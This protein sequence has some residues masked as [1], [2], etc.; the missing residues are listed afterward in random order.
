[1]SV[2]RNRPG[3][4][5]ATSRA[6][7]RAAPRPLKASPPPGDD[8]EGPFLMPPPDSDSDDWQ[9]I[10]PRKPRKTKQPSAPAESAAGPDQTAAMP[11]PLSVTPAATTARRR[12]LG[13][14]LSASGIRLRVF[15]ARP[16]ASGS[17]GKKVPETPTSAPTMP[18]GP[19]PTPSAPSVTPVTKRGRGRPRKTP[20]P[21]APAA[22]VSS[23]P[24]GVGGGSEGPPVSAQG[25]PGVLGGISE[26]LV[27]GPSAYTPRLLPTGMGYDPNQ[28]MPQEPF[29]QWAG[30]YG[31]PPAPSAAASSLVQNIVDQ[32]QAIDASFRQPA[33]PRYTQASFAPLGGWPGPHQVPQQYGPSP[34]QYSPGPPPPAPGP[35]AWGGGERGFASVPTPQAGE[36]DV[37]L[38]SMQQSWTQAPIG[39]PWPAQPLARMGPAGQLPPVR[40]PYGI[41]SAPGEFSSAFGLQSNLLAEQQQR[42]EPIPPASFS[43]MSLELPGG[44]A[45][46]G[47]VETLRVDGEEVVTPR[48]RPWKAKDPAQFS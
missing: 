38:P 2:A 7:P 11:P 8:D 35:W 6:T 23:S 48:K 12:A 37:P 10:R 22:S 18:P 45:V 34:L 17:R 21:P 43:N 47:E 16:R 26:G 28:V 42:F 27:R 4:P 32:S 40:F 41:P 1:M 5:R 29:G 30:Q 39:G 31:Q 44:D 25:V 33:D 15:G 3:D 36:W 13:L 14:R 19:P 9:P 46:A 24:I 20:G